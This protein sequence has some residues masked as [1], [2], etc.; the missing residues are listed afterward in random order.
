MIDAGSAS[1]LIQSV[2]HSNYR[3]GQFV[4]FISPPSLFYTNTPTHTHT[5]THTHTTCRNGSLADIFFSNLAPVPKQTDNPAYCVSTALNGPLYP[6]WWKLFH[7][8]LISYSVAALAQQY[9]NIIKECA[10]VCNLNLPVCIG[11]RVLM[12]PRNEILSGNSW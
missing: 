4:L 5:H 8:N 12:L 7:P 3:S 1:P 10:I 9:F 11:Y 2:A 6:K